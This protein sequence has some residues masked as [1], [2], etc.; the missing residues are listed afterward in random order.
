MFPPLPK[1]G[2]T[3]YE[4]IPVACTQHQFATSS[5]KTLF[6]LGIR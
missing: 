5:F 6:T 1:K 4:N 2:R 3:P